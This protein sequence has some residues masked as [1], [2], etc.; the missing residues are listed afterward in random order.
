M[1]ISLVIKILFCGSFTSP[2]ITDLAFGEEYYFCW[3][4]LS[5]PRCA[6]PT[7][8]LAGLPDSDVGDGCVR[9]SGAVPYPAPAMVYRCVGVIIPPTETV[10]SV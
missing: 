4:E 3:I 7:P 6:E 2:E 1:C 10:L 5:E 8:G 9:F